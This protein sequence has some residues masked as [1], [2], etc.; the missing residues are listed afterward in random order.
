MSFP[1]PFDQLLEQILDRLNALE[2]VLIGRLDAPRNEESK[3]YYLDKYISLSIVAKT[4]GVDRDTL[5]RYKV[6]IDHVKRFNQIY[7]LR[8]SL[9]DFMQS[10]RVVPQIKVPRT[11][12]RKRV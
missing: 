12:K 9:E 5:Y 11:S 10:G 8:D 7:F 1:N 2:K 6:Q 4:L 3:A